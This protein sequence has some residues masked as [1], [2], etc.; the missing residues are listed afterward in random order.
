M[1]VGHGLVALA[2]VTGVFDQLG[3]PRRDALVVGLVA[4]GFGTLPDVDVFYPFVAAVFH[5]GALS[6]MPGTFWGLSTAIHR[7]V[8]HSV[9]VGLW[10]TAGVTLWAYRGSR[11]TWSITDRRVTPSRLAAVG[12]FAVLVGTAAHIGDVLSAATLAVMS[13]GAIG[14]TV[15]AVREGVGSRNIAFA[16]LFGLASHPLGDLLTGQPPRLLYPIDVVL[17]ESRVVLHADPTLHLVGAFLVELGAI[18]VA[19]AV[20][21]RLFDRRLR[22]H[23][24]PQALA[25][26]AFAL[27][28]LAIPPPTLDAATNFVFGA[29]AVGVVGIPGGAVR[30]PFAR[31][32]RWDAVCTSLAAVT[33]AVASY[34]AAYATVA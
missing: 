22:V 9:V 4:A 8:T 28:V 31:D 2:V 32:H 6:A 1:F 7:S 23:V 16:A 24:H 10:T 29:I 19:V 25:G 26:V 21:A 27:V 14:L 20:L 33:L 34:G 5:S 13:L 17:F 3:Y 30:D 12:T 11:W 18:W 15:L